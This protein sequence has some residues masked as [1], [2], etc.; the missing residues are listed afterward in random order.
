MMYM[1]EEREHKTSIAQ[2]TDRQTGKE[3]II[4]RQCHCGIAID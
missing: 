3:Q 4:H 2:N 1:N